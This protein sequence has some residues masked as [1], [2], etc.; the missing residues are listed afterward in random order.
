MKNFLKSLAHNIEAVK[1]EHTAT[2][3]E[4]EFGDTAGY[5]H[6]LRTKAVSHR[7]EADI[8]RGNVVPVNSEYVD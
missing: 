1:L 8:A 4:Q 7:L 5:S 6:Q 3:L 2:R